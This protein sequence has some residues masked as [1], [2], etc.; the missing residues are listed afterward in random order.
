MHI[1]DQY[2]S[3]GNKF[4]DPKNCYQ[5][6][7]GNRIYQNL[8]VHLEIDCQADFPLLTIRPVRF[9]LINELLQATKLS[10]SDN[11]TE[12]KEIVSK[13]LKTQVMDFYKVEPPNIEDFISEDRSITYEVA[14]TYI[15]P[16]NCIHTDYNYEK[17]KG[18]D[19]YSGENPS[20]LYQTDESDPT[21][22]KYINSSVNLEFSNYIFDLPYDIAFFALQLCVTAKAQKLIANKLFL[23]IRRVVLYDFQLDIFKVLQQRKG[24][25]L[26]LPKLVINN[27]DPT[28]VNLLSYRSLPGLK[29]NA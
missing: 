1:D 12:K 9:D 7:N 28:I 21:K 3:L 5:R 16:Y 17:Y 18:D 10:Y 11:Y 13:N 23:N 19:F 2:L 27:N 8:N 15:F 14:D 20:P 29:I 25:R 4:L 24:Q 26:N 6:D 22:L